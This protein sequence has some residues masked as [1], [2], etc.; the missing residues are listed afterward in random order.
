MKIATLLSAVVLGVSL[1]AQATLYD[2]G[3]ANNGNIPDGNPTGWSDTRTVS[4]LGTLIQSLSVTLNLSGGYN[5]D[6]YAYLSYDG[7][8]LVLLNRVGVGTGSSPTFTFGYSGAGFSSLV[9]QDGGVN[10]DIHTYGGGVGTG[11][12]S[13]DGRAVSPVVNNSA[14]AT[15]LYGTSRDTFNSK[16]GGLNPNGDWT[17]FIADMSGGGGQTHVDSWGLNI[18]AVP[19]PV[20]V[21]LGV[22]GVVLAG[23]GIVRR[24][25]VRSRQP[26]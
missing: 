1:S 7:T 16:F 12:Y 18:T 24:L 23:C 19:E 26:D 2:S 8:K 15:A 21:A 11:T 22:F 20:N 9:L 13:A 25:C 5:G 6:L 3:F 4:G 10:G 17:L 14:D